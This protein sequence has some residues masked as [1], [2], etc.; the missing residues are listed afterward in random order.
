MFNPI[1]PC[2]TPQISKES[3]IVPPKSPTLNAASSSQ[4]PPGADTDSRILP[5]V[6]TTAESVNPSSS[7]IP[8]VALEPSPIHP[9]ASPQENTQSSSLQF[10][11]LVQE[12]L[13]TKIPVISQDPTQSFPKDF[14]RDH[15]LPSNPGLICKKTPFHLKNQSK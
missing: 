15:I 10:P 13:P 4:S 12:Q 6:T 7:D 14:T 11:S 8:P 2:P 1:A 5:L 3:A 9:V